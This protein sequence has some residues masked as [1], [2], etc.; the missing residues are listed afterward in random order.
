MEHR[1]SAR[2]ERPPASPAIASAPA[3]LVELDAL[4]GI[5]ATLVMLFHYTTRYDQLYGHASS[6]VL[7][8][9]WGYL[10]VNLFF[11]ISGFVIFMTL[12]RVR[13]PLDF[14]VSRFSRLFPA[15]WAAVLLTFLLTH[16]FALPHKTVGVDTAAMNLFMLHGLVKIPNVDGVYW[17][18]EI[19]LIFYCMALMMFLTGRL[20]RVHA[21]LMALLGLR[22]GYYLADKLAGIELSWTLSQL[23]ILPYIAWFALGI[24][25]YR[26]TAA[27]D[28]SPRLDW[29]V[30]VTAIGLVGVVEGVGMALL[31]CLFTIVL[32]LATNGRLPVLNNPLLIWLGAISYTLYLLHENIGWGV[33]RMAEQN[34]IAPS[35]AIAGAIGVALT[36]ATGLTYLIERPAMKWL[37][38]K[39]RNGTM[40]SA[41]NRTVLLACAGILSLFASLAYAWHKTNPPRAAVRSLPVTFS[42]S[43]ADAVACRLTN[44]RP[45][46]LLVLGQSNAGN[47]GT[48]AVLAPTTAATFF[49][50]GGCYRTAGPTPG[51]TGRGTS[52]WTVL[53]PMLE[54]RIGR[55]VLFSVLAVEATTVHDWVASGPLRD[56]LRETLADQHRHGFLPD[57]VLWQQGEADAKAG[58]STEAYA[59]DF[60]ELTAFLRANGVSAPVIAALSTRCR[61][62][63]SDA[64]RLALARTA[65]RD[66]SVRIGPDTDRLSGPHYRHD[67]CHFSVAGAI[68]AAHG[69][70]AAV[71]SLPGVTQPAR[72]DH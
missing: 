17:T 20:D 25:V 68:E 34:G 62:Q 8:L 57:A 59:R 72:Q 41:S 65:G 45:L 46:M 66:P 50:D 19:E 12:H 58:T 51:A 26:R 33:I 16:A 56:R 52:I 5:A 37:R 60:E 14:M 67:E 31:A 38:A 13:R 69:W 18:L 44:P 55:P 40:A 43:P 32:R 1:S 24:M 48:P 54:Q 36:L 64:V 9:P 61:N 70:A 28:E 6:P 53:G 71:Q 15:Y 27:P 29:A 21:F 47:H 63:G 42:P 2:T 4:R 30:F 3:R 7:E 35:I 49:F 39:Y 22:L 10:G 11:M 23:L